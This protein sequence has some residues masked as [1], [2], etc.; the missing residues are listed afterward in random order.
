MLVY[1]P[2][3]S[4]RLGYS[5]GVNNIPPK[6]CSYACIYCQVGRTDRLCI[7]RQTFY[8]PEKIVTQIHDKVRQ[9]RES[10]N[11]IDYITFVPDGEPTLDSNLLWIIQQIQSL[12]IKI[13]VIS[14]ASLTYL[15]DV[16]SALKQAD[17]VSLKIDA[18]KQEVWKAINR[19][20]GGLKLNE[21]L[22]G[23]QSF[24]RQYYGKLITE[25][26]LLEGWNTDL[27]N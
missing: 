16:Q 7:R 12:K 1:G 24:S 26:M 3:P 21:I 15:T 14:N 19:P 27:N 23:I 11:R 9:V 2:V 13:A 17:L 25:T 10:S 8:D 20:H 18:V 6:V 5:M 22:N 4:R